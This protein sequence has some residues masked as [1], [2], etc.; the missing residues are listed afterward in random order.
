MSSA[1]A[2]VLPGPE[3]V[4][5]DLPK[6]SKVRKDGTVQLPKGMWMREDGTIGH[7][8]HL[9]V[10][11]RI[12]KHWQLHTFVIL[13]VIFFVIFRYGPMLG[14]IIAF[15]RYN[16]GDSM[17]GHGPLTLLFIKQFIGQKMFWNVF[18]NN[19]I[20]G[21]LAFVFCFPLPIV[22]ALL[23]NELKFMKFKKVVQTISYLPHFLS[24]VIVVGIIM[25]L[26][27][28]GGILNNA[29]H[30]FFPNWANL[31]QNASAIRPIY[32]ISE[33]WQTTG[34]GTILYLAALTTVDE[35]L[36]EAAKLDGAGRWRQTWHVTLPGIRHTMVVLFILNIGTFLAV[37]FEKLLLL[38]SV[39][40][41]LGQGDVIATYVYRVGLQGG[42][43]SFG[44]AV[45]LFESLIGLIL[46]FGSNTI[47][48][49]LTGS[50][51]W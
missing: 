7:A 46:V 32:V 19:I 23:L 43:Y 16:P 38:I 49:R 2:E 37:G 44:T 14:N 10:L 51:L 28:S 11:Q 35:Q 15:R 45:G 36:Y 27:V 30:I 3:P 18:M 5:L 13:P 1:V 25:E 33:I 9:T 41:W 39:G 17:F 31:F 34:W 12:R 8:N 6:G 22:L 4:T 50:S 26:S 29:I 20:I 21:L 24:V 48:R 47:A 40:T 42:Q